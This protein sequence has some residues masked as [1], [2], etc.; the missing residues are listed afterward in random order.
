MRKIP[1]DSYISMPILT[2]E[3]LI[4]RSLRALGG[5]QDAA[6]IHMYLKRNFPSPPSMQIGLRRLKSFL[7]KMKTKGQ[8]L[9]TLFS[10]E[11]DHSGRYLYQLPCSASTCKCVGFSNSMLVHFEK[12]LSRGSWLQLYM[13]LG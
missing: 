5:W 2:A 7:R 8:V 11:S 10:P 9:R 3:E 13:Y 6:S 1:K 4:V 12:S